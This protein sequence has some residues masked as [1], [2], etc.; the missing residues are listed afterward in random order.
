[1]VSKNHAIKGSC[2]FIGRRPSRYVT[3]L[4]S[5]LAKDIVVVEMFLLCHMIWYDHLIKESYDFTPHPAT[6]GS[7]R[8]S[9]SRYIRFFVVEEQDSTC[10]LSSAII[11]FP[12][13]LDMSCSHKQHFRL[14]KHFP[15]K[16][17]PVSPMKSVQYWSHESRATIHETYTKS[18]CWSD[19]KH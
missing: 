18:F 13:A 15:S 8:Y 17:F 10:L 19:Q 1:M 2:D 7:Y 14:R 12:K 11:I 6:F 4:P 9:G 5:L 3:V 16:H